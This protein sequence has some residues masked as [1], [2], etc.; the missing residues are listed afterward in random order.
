MQILGDPGLL[1]AWSLLIGLAW[2][3]VREKG[4]K[5]RQ[6]CRACVAICTALLAIW[7][8]GTTIFLMTPEGTIRYYILFDGLNI[9]VLLPVFLMVMDLLWQIGKLKRNDV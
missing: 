4:I 7:T 2:L 5:D 1:A 8:V 9:L 6:L 3:F